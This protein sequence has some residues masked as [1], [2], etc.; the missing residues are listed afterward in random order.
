MFQHSNNPKGFPEGVFAARVGWYQ[1]FG[2]YLFSYEKAVELLYQKVASGEETPDSIVAPLVF[3][4]RHSLELGYKYTLVELHYLNEVPYD[5]KKFGHHSLRSLHA[6]LKE[7]FGKVAAKWSLSESMLEDFARRYDKTQAGME[8]FDQLDSSS[9][10]FRY[11]IDKK[12]GNLVFSGGETVNLLSLKQLYDDA[13]ILLRHTAD[14]L[15]PAREMLEE[16]HQEM[17]AQVRDDIA[18]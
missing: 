4:M 17:W 16:F 5:S 2:H 11:P 6:A 1:S 9:F 18:W 14:V 12:T 15:S 7:W 13:M 8:E 3:L 10:R